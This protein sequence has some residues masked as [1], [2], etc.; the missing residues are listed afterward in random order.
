MPIRS[1]SLKQRLA[2]KSRPADNLNDYG[3]EVDPASLANWTT[4]ETVY[5][6]VTERSASELRIA[7]ADAGKVYHEVMLRWRDN[8]GPGNVALT[9]AHSF[10]YGGRWLDIKGVRNAGMNNREYLIAI[11]EERLT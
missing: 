4:V 7:D 3:E 1:G 2:I 11:C 6:A 5:G 8:F 10:D 9:P